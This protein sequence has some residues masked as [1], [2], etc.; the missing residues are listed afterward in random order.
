VSLAQ[1]QAAVRRLLR[2]RIRLGMFDP[3]TAVP[4][5]AITHADVGSP[6]HVALAEAGARA[7][8][9]L[10][11]N[12][13]PA[14]GSA[15][16]LPLALGGLKRIALVGP[17][18][19]ASYILLGSY[20]DPGCCKA[21]GGIPTVLQ[22]LGSRAAAAGVAV[23]YAPGCVNAS[24]LDTAGF[25]GAA[26]AA[27][28]ADAVVLVLGMGQTANYCGGN[29]DRT[30]CESESHD[31]DTC[32]L[33]GGQP[34]LVAAVR[35]A[36]TR[37]GVPVVAVLVHGG[38]LCLLPATLGAVD[39]L[40]DAWYPGM[41]G[42]AAVADA[43]VGAFSPAGRSPVTWYA[44]DAALP[45]D[46]GNMSPYPNASARSPGVTYRFYDEAPAAG[47]A[48]VVF[49]FG[50]GLSYTT[51]AVSAPQA[52]AAVGPC[53]PLPLSVTVANTGA[54]AS[55]VV[56]QAFLAQPDAA[57]PGPVTRLV[58]FARVAGLAPGE[59]RAVALPPIPAAGRSLVHEAGG[60]GS[61][62][63]A[64]AGKR[65]NEAGRLQLRIVTGQHGGDRAGGLAVT[66]TQSASQDLATC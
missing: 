18:A 22:E 37:P 64:V 34:A 52:P 30:A 16:A 59:R 14:G 44:S 26:A 19:N 6:A 61:D 63:F 5:N 42:A 35:A 21:G 56:L 48:P 29:K 11:Q 20:S 43:L 17:N 62:I 47:G 45:A 12:N 9:T 31:R 28:A 54:V 49:S 25:A 38:A 2:V 33:P 10:L 58:A 41:R 40:L 66:V 65:W 1:V 7:G 51:F 23:D 53:D 60:D 13:V 24:C 27:G 4:Y 8:M 15:P 3:P 36:V 55:D 32:A 57:T 46:R 39:G 50:E